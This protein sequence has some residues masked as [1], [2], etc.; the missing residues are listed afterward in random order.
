MSLRLNNL[1]ISY[2]KYNVI[3]DVSIKINKGDIVS[4]IGRN[5]CG[6]STV[7]KTIINLLELDS[8]FVEFDKTDVRKYKRKDLAKKIAFLSQQKLSYPDLTVETLVS[9]GRYPHLKFGKF[10]NSNDKKII[11]E[12]L[13]KTGVYHL[14][15][16]SI[17]KL[18]GGERQRAWIAMAICQEPEILILDEPTTY[19]DVA[20]QIEV[21]D[22]IKELNETL[23]M[24]IVMVLHDINLASRYSKTIYAIKDKKV[25]A[26]GTPNMIVCPRVLEEVFTI[27]GDFYVDEENKCPFFIPKKSKNKKE[28]IK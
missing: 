5:G 22:L 3:D 17:K 16:K 27:N 15:D 11:D 14:K 26:C 4:I 8:G 21:L 28:E 7:L 12:S 18:S 2:E 13:K 19:L 23:G 6:K 25:F 24:T 20:Y 9:Y 10:L 1:K